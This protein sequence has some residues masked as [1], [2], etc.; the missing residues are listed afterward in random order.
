MGKLVLMRR[1]GESIDVTLTEPMPAGTHIEVGVENI[2]RNRVRVWIEADQSI[3]ID[4]HEITLRKQ[5]E[6]GINGNVAEPVE[7]VHDECAD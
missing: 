2:D 4:R 1:T 5:R 7:E 3:I 6:A